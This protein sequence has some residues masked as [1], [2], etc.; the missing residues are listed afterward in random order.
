MADRIGELAATKFYSAGVSNAQQY[1]AGVEAAMAVANAKLAGKGLKLA[2]VKGISAGFNDAISPPVM[3]PI[4][5]PTPGYG[6]P[7][8]GVTVNVSGGISTSAEIGEAVV[9]AIRA[10]NRAAGPADI[11]VTR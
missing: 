5:K 2:D 9:N 1:L 7:G 6:G 10:Y 11:A 3:A 8:G 4:S